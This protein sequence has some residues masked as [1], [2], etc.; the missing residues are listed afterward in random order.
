MK[1]LSIGYGRTLFDHHNSERSRLHACATEL[2]SVHH[3]VFA[4]SSDGLA[5]EA[6]GALALYPTNARSRIGMF[7]AAYRIG[8]RILRT[9]TIDVITAQDPLASGFVAWLLAKVYKKP[10]VVQ[11]HGD[12]FSDSYWRRECLGNR[13]WY[14]LARFLI[15]RADRVRV[16]SERVRRHVEACGVPQSRIVTLPVFSPA[17]IQSEVSGGV[18]LRNEFPEASI[19]VL[20]V[21][22]FVAQKNLSLLL[23]AFG[24]LLEKE[25]RAQLVLVGRGPLEAALKDQAMALGITQHVAFMPWSADVAALMR[26]ADV[27][28]LSSNY[29]GWARVLPEAMAWGL[30][31][32]TTDVGCV[33]ERFIH[34]RHGLVVEVGNEQAFLDALLRCCKDEELRR[35]MGEVS[36]HDSLTIEGDLSV[37]ARAWAAVYGD[38]SSIN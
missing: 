25:P 19:I 23:R 32:V 28:A 35:T 4:R 9:E 10:F 17:A 1:L 2:G 7:V 38:I 22:R 8:A 13:L 37:Y 3:I 6:E 29:E 26:S 27:Y 15:R 20:S 30:P 12:I 14:P 36:R 24:S 16:V 34:E 21:A 31:T 11:E 18:S 5:Y 33:G